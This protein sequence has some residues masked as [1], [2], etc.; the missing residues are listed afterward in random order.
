[1]NNKS[2]SNDT[3]NMKSSSKTNMKIYTDAL[4]R[5]VKSDSEEDII[6][7]YF[8]SINLLTEGNVAIN[9]WSI[10]AFN[11]AIKTRKQLH[12]ARDVAKKLDLLAD[13]E[14]QNAGL[15]LISI[16]SNSESASKGALSGIS[17]LW[18]IVKGGR[19]R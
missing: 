7:L 9:M 14:L 19:R 18:A 4:N 10:R 5:S 17:K 1:M 11:G 2:A 15:T 16:A 13:L 3:T 8:D 6:N 12:N